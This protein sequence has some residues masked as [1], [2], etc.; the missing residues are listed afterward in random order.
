MF[1][2]VMHYHVFGSGVTHCM[3][4]TLMAASVCSTQ[5]DSLSVSVWMVTCDGVGVSGEVR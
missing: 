3:F 1:M 2:V 5:P 4:C